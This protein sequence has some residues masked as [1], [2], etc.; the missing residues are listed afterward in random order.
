MPPKL[1]TYLI[2]VWAVV[3][4][5]GLGVFL[6]ELYGP[7]SDLNSPANQQ[8]PMVTAVFWLIMWLAPTVVMVIAARR[9]DNDGA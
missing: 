8:N 7:G 2:I 4:F 6:F 1:F 3:C 9:Q 5:S